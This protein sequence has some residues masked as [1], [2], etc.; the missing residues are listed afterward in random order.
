MIFMKRVSY[1]Y[2]LCSLLS[3]DV[4][5]HTVAP[6][7]YTVAITDISKSMYLLLIA[8]GR[9]LINPQRSIDC[10]VKCA[11]SLEHIKLVSL[12]ISSLIKSSCSRLNIRRF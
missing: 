3:Q 11:M 9:L 10:D 4:R 5:G 8:F 7:I 6:V 1:D 2:V 12:F